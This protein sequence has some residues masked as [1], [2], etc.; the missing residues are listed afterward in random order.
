MTAPRLIVL[1]ELDREGS[2][3]PLNDVYAAAL[4]ETG[5]VEVRPERSEWRL[6]PR[7]MVGSTRIGELQVE[8]RPKKKVG[9]TRLLF[10]LGYASNPGFRPE[11][12]EPRQTRT[13]G[14]RWPSRWRG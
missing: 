10:L 8:V 11:D 6:L 14:R 4:A 12:V 9:L 7:G 13:C 3:E 2:L 5:L 1:D